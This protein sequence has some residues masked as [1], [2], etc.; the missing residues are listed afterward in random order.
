MGGVVDV[1]R[2]RIA[3]VDGGLQRRILLRESP[4]AAVQEGVFGGVRLEDGREHA[5]LHPAGEELG[6]AG[7]LDAGGEHV[8][9]DIMAP[10]AVA[11]VAGRGGEIGQETEHLPVD[12][13]VA[14]EAQLVA[15][16]AE[17]APAVVDQ[18]PVGLQALG[19]GLADLVVPEGVVAP[20]GV[21]QA[22][23]VLALP[24][25]LPVEPPEV[26][27][28][29]LHRP[30]DRCEIGVRP[31]LL[32]QPE[33]HR[34]AI[35]G[36]SGREIVAGELPAA[37]GID[38]ALGAVIF[39]RPGEIVFDKGVIGV[40]IGPD[41]RGRVEIQRHLEILAVQGPQ[42]AFRVRDQVVVPAVARPAAR[43][44]EFVRTEAP[45]HLRPGQVPVHVDDEHVGGD[46]ARAH[47][48]RKRQQFLVG[49]GP[50]AAPPVAEHIPRRQRDLPGDAREVLQR[51]HVVVSI[52][53]EIEVHAVA[54]RTRRHP[55]APVAAVLFQ[56]VPVALVDKGPSVAGQEPLLELVHAE[57]DLAES[58][59]AVQRAGRS[60]EV[61]LV[62]LAGEPGDRAAV[63]LEPNLQVVGAETP[64]S[65]GQRQG[66]C[67]DG[68]RPAAAAFREGGHR[69]LAVDHS[70]AGA[71]LELTV[72][73]PF[74][75]DQAVCQDG[76]AGIAL[77]HDGPGVG[78]GI[79][80][81]NGKAGQGGYG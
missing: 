16:A 30:D 69:Q 67:F 8:P 62:L 1:R 56:Q 11:D 7:L 60:A 59:A 57:T 14:G 10:V 73:R 54:L 27:P 3:Q 55:F 18:R 71:V 48:V 80:G 52:G 75:A 58:L 25:L 66:V 13:G 42:Q 65:V 41:A 45:V 5:E 77:G 6:I 68:Q 37:V 78:N 38:I 20:E 24:P 23:H 12:E 46:V 15:V 21:R 50:V 22:G 31:G 79:L 74:H 70:E 63:Q 36:R 34:S 81:E 29:L 47:L 44:P 17:A 2:Q 53:E 64:A 9:A 39:L 19:T 76:K 61:A 4:D 49:V 35:A 51:G 33:R 40:L 43:L 32:V 72:F 28:L 26:D